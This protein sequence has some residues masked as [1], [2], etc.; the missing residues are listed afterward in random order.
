MSLDQTQNFVRATIASAVD[1][2]DTTIDVTDSNQLPDPADGA[3]NLIL[4]DVSTFPRPGQDPAVEVVRATALDEAADELAVDRGQENTTAA[5]H[6]ETAVLQLS[7]TA[8]MFADIDAK[9]SA[10]SEDGQT[11]DGE[12][13]VTED[14]NTP[15]RSGFSAPP[16]DWEF[17]DNEHRDDEEDI[18]GLYNFNI[19]TNDYDEFLIFAELQWADGR[20][21]I[22]LVLN[23]DND[24]GNYTHIK[25][26]DSRTSGADRFFLS[27]GDTGGVV[28]TTTVI[29]LTRSGANNYDDWGVG[30]PVIPWPNQAYETPVLGG[31]FDGGQ[32]I[33]DIGFEAG[34]RIFSDTWVDI[35]GREVVD[36]P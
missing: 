22:F 14:I 23:Q 33:T 2:A 3:Y 21:G 7:P 16:F 32:Q 20:D 4:W 9:T 11:F 19:G 6:P 15:D 27:S 30:F 26:D 24:N 18:S 17:I 13:V 10:L 31:S 12:S 29:R 25:V 36:H 1:S 35:Y 34:D 28:N 5:D 8:K